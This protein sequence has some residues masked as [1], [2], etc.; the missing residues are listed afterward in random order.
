MDDFQLRLIVALERLAGRGEGPTPGE[1][2]ANRL[3]ALR[4]VL[5]DVRDRLP[6]ISED[7]P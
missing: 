3:D 4:L 7:S 5:E 6:P 1:V 2:L